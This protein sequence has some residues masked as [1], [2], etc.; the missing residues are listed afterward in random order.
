MKSKIFALLFMCGLNILADSQLDPE[1]KLTVEQEKAIQD[2]A[3][4][5][6]K[7]LVCGLFYKVWLFQILERTLEDLEP[8]E[9][10][11]LESVENKVCENLFKLKCPVRETLVTEMIAFRQQ[12][13]DARAALHEF[14]AQHDL[15]EDDVFIAAI[16]PLISEPDIKNFV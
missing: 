9:L 14:I 4:K 5:T 6:G 16:K 15:Q 8:K 1:V 13:L 7:D 11:R 12:M 10:E 3:D 2:F